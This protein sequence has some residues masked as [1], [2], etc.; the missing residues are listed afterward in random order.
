MVPLPCKGRGGDGLE[1]LALLSYISNTARSP[2]M[3][4]IRRMQP[5]D[6]TIAIVAFVAGAFIF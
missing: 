3:D 4:F 1:P 6:W 5:K 2:H